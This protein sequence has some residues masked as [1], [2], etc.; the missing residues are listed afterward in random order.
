MP[1]RII[2][3]DDHAI[4]RDGLRSLLEQEADMYIVA[5]AANGLEVIR[6]AREHQPDAIVMDASMPNLNGIEATRT[7]RAQLPKTRII[8]LSMHNESRFVSAMLGA[9]ASGYLLKDC[10]SEEFVRAIRTVMAGQVYL[11]PGIGQ[12]VVD[13]LT[14]ARA[15]AGDSAFS[16]LTDRERA[17][18]QLLAEGHTTKEMAEHLSLSAKTVATHR[19]HL[20]A[21][22]GI[23]SIAGLTRYAIQQGL[24]VLDT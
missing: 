11:S 3:A 20:M 1:I 6:A 16:R 2:L 15:D 7:I 5:E 14:A 9:G 13:Q 8:C 22:L 12:V 23:T 17:V 18:L 21:K 19:E 4:V 24:T 10:A